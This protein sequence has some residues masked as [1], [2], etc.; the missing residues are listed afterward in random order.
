[1]GRKGLIREVTVTKGKDS[2]VGYIV[3]L[4]LRDKGIKWIRGRGR[5]YMGRKGKTSNNNEGKG[6]YR[7]LHCLSLSL[8]LWE[9]RG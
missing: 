6:L 5:G 9:T 4:C 8:S 3:S 2:T 7:R 1:M